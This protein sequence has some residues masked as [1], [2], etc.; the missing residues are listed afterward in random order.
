MIA[1][2]KPQVI[3]VSGFTY[4]DYILKSSICTDETYGGLLDKSV[5]KAP[6]ATF[7]SLAEHEKMLQGVPEDAQAILDYERACG[8]QVK[9]AL[10]Y[11]QA[12]NMTDKL[13]K[14]NVPIQAFLF[15]RI[16]EDR[17]HNLHE[18]LL[19][20][21]AGFELYRACMR[22]RPGPIYVVCSPR[23]DGN[24]EREEAENTLFTKS[25]LEEHTGAGQE[26]KPKELPSP[27]QGRDLESKLEIVDKIKSYRMHGILY[28][29]EQGLAIDLLRNINRDPFAYGAHVG[30]VIRSKED[31]LNPEPAEEVHEQEERPI[32]ETYEESVSVPKDPVIADPKDIANIRKDAA[33]KSVMRALAQFSKK[34]K[35]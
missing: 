26:K 24:E 30:T 1:K 2:H 23:T 17:R 9:L 19:D 8:V 16:I 27:K 18:I 35:K 10:N 20:Q 13:L 28:L 3:I 25:D 33:A 4:R 34:Q 12:F 14:H 22:M 7:G 29:E 6:T 31:F 11:S 5:E 21:Q 32:D 15:Y